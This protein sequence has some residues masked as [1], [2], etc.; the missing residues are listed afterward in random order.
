VLMFLL[1]VV[2]VFFVPQFFVITVSCE[3]YVNFFFSLCPSVVYEFIFLYIISLEHF[4]Y[5]TSRYFFCLSFFFIMMLCVTAYHPYFFFICVAGIHVTMYLLVRAC[6]C[7]CARVRVY[8]CPRCMR[9]VMFVVFV[10]C[11]RVC[12]C[13]AFFFIHVCF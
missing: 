5:L 4:F 12:A 7:V 3:S 1:L 11:L 6:V 8:E 9:C 2:V 10:V 13:V